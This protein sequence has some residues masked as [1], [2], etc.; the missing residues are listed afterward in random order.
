MG[1]KVWSLAQSAADRWRITGR[2]ARGPVGSG[3]TAQTTDW[4]SRGPLKRSTGKLVASE[5]RSNQS[6]RRQVRLLKP[7]LTVWFIGAATITAAALQTRVPRSA[8]FLDQGA[9]SGI[10]WYVGILSN[11]GY[12]VW[13]VAASAAFGGGW[14]A[15]QTRRPSAAR[16]LFAGGVVTVVLLLDDMF[17]VHSSV[18]SKAIGLPKPVSLLVIVGP[19][20]VWLGVFAGE[21]LRTRWLVLASALAMLF[22]SIVADQALPGGETSL[23]IEDGAKFLG[24][25]GWMVYF[26]LT[27][28]DIARSTIGEAMRTRRAG[29]E[30]PPEP[31]TAL[32][33]V[34]GDLQYL[35]AAGTVS[36]VRDVERVVGSHRDTG[37]EEQPFG[38]HVGLGAVG[39]DLD[40]RTERSVE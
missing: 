25:L 10:S 37:R 13:T 16:F 8:L 12:I 5:R 28:H 18:L 33:S 32:L 23:L 30:L 7:L 31:V 14:V 34:E 22:C 35:A 24:V 19:A 11:I 38:D 17:R 9:L 40:Q 4:F 1:P 29:D 15:N 36:T 20:I 27:S 2:P 3:R 6:A 21:V 39:R 26:V